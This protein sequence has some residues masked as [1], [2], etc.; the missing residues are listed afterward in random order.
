MRDTNPEYG[1]V[2]QREKFYLDIL[3][4]AVE[5]GIN[6]WA[7]VVRYK[8]V[9]PRGGQRADT[10]AV[11]IDA[12]DDDETPKRHDVTLATI[13][14]GINLLRNGGGHHIKPAPE[15]FHK[16]WRDAY[17]GCGDASWDFDAGDADCVVQAGL[18]GEVVYG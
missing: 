15:W 17:A 4:T 13:R 3:T 18:F 12:E 5:G 16:K 11:V 2:A 9:D 14:K 1:A 10:H 7:Q 8:W 6:Y